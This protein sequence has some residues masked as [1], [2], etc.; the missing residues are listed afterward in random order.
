MEE[1]AGIRKE[2]I[3]E[4]C[5]EVRDGRRHQKNVVGE[6]D[7]MVQVR[8]EDSRGKEEEGIEKVVE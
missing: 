6:E 5:D 3:D 2:G 8:E 7:V 1:G 4:E